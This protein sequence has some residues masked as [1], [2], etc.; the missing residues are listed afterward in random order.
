M[1]FFGTC[2]AYVKVICAGEERRT[3]T[4][5]ATAPSGPLFFRA[6]RRVADDPEPPL[7]PL[8]PSPQVRDSLDPVWG[9]DAPALE[10]AVPPGVDALA[11]CALC[12]RSG[13]G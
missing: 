2:D 13:R 12:P 6:A 1:D 8:S 10:F 7:S 3:A 5:R 11:V 9:A 4:V